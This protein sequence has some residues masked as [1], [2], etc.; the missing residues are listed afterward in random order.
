[1]QEEQ[2][3]VLFIPDNK[4]FLFHK[5]V[6]TEQNRPASGV[7]MIRIDGARVKQLREERGLTQ[8]YL[9][10][11]VEVTTDTISRWENRH[12]PTI[13]R[14][15]GLRLAEALEVDLEEILEKTAP[16]EAEQKRLQKENE[17]AESVLPVTR[18]GVPV[19][20]Y[21]LLLNIALAIMIPAVIGLVVW[22]KKQNTADVELTAVRALPV[23]CA[24]GLQF[25]V[26]IT[27]K[28]SRTE[29]PL[30]IRE[31]V[32]A[33]VHITKTMPQTPVQNGGSL[34]WIRK[35]GGEQQ[36]T[37]Y[38]AKAQGKVGDMVSFSGNIAVRQG[39]KREIVIKGD[40][41]L[42]LAP[43]HWADIN[44]DL[45]ICDDEVLEAYDKFG[46][47]PEFAGELDQVEEIWMGSGYRWDE[48]M[49]KITILP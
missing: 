45:V 30:L 34:K 9:A 27:V 26:A 14:E 3:S 41:A 47:I 49:Q 13:K 46:K 36:V 42:R 7:P 24:P 31:T 25:P 32:P 12:Y 10:T 48:K 29:L 8:L 40:A 5:I 38:L 20:T 17:P 16:P 43:M 22:N 44:G 21:N 33:T 2:E 37:G 15:N 1:L 35:H 39:K 28:S 4:R 6:M 23:S 19:K 18:A 11:A